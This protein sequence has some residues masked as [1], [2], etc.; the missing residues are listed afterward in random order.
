MDVESGKSSSTVQERFATLGPRAIEYSGRASEERAIQAAQINSQVH[1]SGISPIGWSPAPT[2]GERRNGQ[3]L[4]SIMTH[5]NDFGYPRFEK[6]ELL[7]GGYC[8]IADE[9][10]GRGFR[11]PV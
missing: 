5:V 1:R 7:A 6:K 4:H 2:R 10:T 9:R 8:K 3:L 11:T